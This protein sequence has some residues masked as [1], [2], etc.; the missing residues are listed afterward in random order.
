[1]KPVASAQTKVSAGPIRL[2]APDEIQHARPFDRA[3]S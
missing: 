2:R 3:V 1:M